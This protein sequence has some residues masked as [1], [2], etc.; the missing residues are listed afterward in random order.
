MIKKYG[1]M[2]FLGRA[3][4]G[5]PCARGVGNPWG[6]AYSLNLLF[7]MSGGLSFVFLRAKLFEGH[8]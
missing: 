7:Q 4:W 6:E 3:V 1:P 2:L 5:V 8:V